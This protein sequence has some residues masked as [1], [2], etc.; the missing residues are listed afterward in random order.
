MKWIGVGF[1]AECR[2]R[3]C[4]AGVALVCLWL[5]VVMVVVAQAGLLLAAVRLPA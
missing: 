1:F 5:L 2:A 3:V 4:W